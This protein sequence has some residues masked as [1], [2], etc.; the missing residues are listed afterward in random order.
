[1]P[2]AQKTS[3]IVIV[4]AGLAGLF[5]ALR[6]AP[7]P[8]TVIAAAPM[9]EGASSAWAQGG[10][11]AAVGEGDS[12]AAHASDT[13][14]AGAG[15]VDEDIANLVAN[16]A[17]ARVMD[18]LT[19]GVP[20]DK[21][22]EDK[23]VLSR[24]AAH[25]AKRV[26]RVA[27]DGAGRAIMEAVI[28]AV[29]Q[30]PSIRVLEGLTVSGL[31]AS[32][33]GQFELLAERP[34]DPAAQLVITDADAVVLA[35]GGVGALYARSTN[36][37]TSRG[38]GIALAARAGAA[39][40]DSEFV[41]FHPT[42]ID[43]STVPIPLATESL[44]GEGATLINDA[45]ERFMLAHHRDGELGPRDIVARGVYTEIQS[46]NGAFLDCREAIGSEFPERF[47][48]VYQ[49]CKAAGIDPVLEPI[50]VVPAEH[51]H[52]GGIKTDDRGRTT[53]AN[54]WAI[55]EAAS[56]GLHGANRLASNSLLEAV[57][58]GNRTAADISDNVQPKEIAVERVKS[59]NLQDDDA[60][61]MA[62][63]LIRETMAL[64]VGV[65]RNQDDL[66]FALTELQDIE[67]A[68]Q[69]DAVVQNAAITAR[70]I[71]EAALRR[72]ESRGAHFREDY[73]EPIDA[74][75]K[76]QSM[77]LT[78]LNLR[79]NL[80]AQRTLTEIVHAGKRVDDDS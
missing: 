58:F 29:R 5:T 52:M 6:L 55:G 26:V 42:A 16:E 37:L 15:I 80:G 48:V 19:F 59:D 40:A 12:P 4:G 73:P 38:S 69:D 60:R 43:V 36:P 13:I 31:K 17:N 28:A 14:A 74:M 39:I 70:F 63:G 34:E 62:L 44:R 79:S 41:Q 77:T 56:T 32:E 67:T 3:S 2:D 61:E 53:V 65:V 68:A 66:R 72:K 64:N 57:V 76:R 49:Q 50:P 7:L 8:V 78:G 22:L 27:G 75:A 21:D 45:G 47:A 1:M 71:T 51:Y 35:T 18:L 10:I 20:F 25:S 24:E 54:L 30:T 11:A 9:G 33:T 23:L 46:G